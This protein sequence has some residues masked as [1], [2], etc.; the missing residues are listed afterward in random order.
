ME[1]AEEEEENDF[2][3]LKKIGVLWR[4]NRRRRTSS[5]STLHRQPRLWCAY[6]R[7]S[8]SFTSASYWAQRVLYFSPSPVLGL[9]LTPSE[10]PTETERARGLLLRR[11]CVRD[12]QAQTSGGFDTQMHALTLLCSSRTHTHAH[13]M[14]PAA[15]SS[16]ITHPPP[17]HRPVSPTA[18]P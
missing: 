13:R 10:R 14:R 15:S 3:S 18:T 17:P 1:V 12:A 16:T 7:P 9:H 6:Y 2:Q 5:C 8:S 11:T 4:A